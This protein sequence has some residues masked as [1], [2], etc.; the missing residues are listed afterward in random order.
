MPLKN[1][2]AKLFDQMRGLPL[3][4]D[5]A[6]SDYLAMTDKFRAETD[7]QAAVEYCRSMYDVDPRAEGIINEMAQD[8]VKGGFEIRAPENIKAQDIATGLVKRLD[9]QHRLVSWVRET[10]IDGNQ[11]L[12]IAIDPKEL[13]ITDALSLPSL[14]VRRNS[15][16]FD[17]ILDPVK[18]FQWSPLG[19]QLDDAGTWLAEWETIHARW[20]RR[21]NAKYGRPMF[22]SAITAYKR[23]TEG[24]LDMAVRRK[25][26][27][28][29]R[30]LHVLEGLQKDQI[31]EYKKANAEALN[32]PR[33]AVQDF[34]S[35]TKA[36]LTGIQGDAHLA[37]VADVMHHIETWGTSSP[38]PLELLGYGGSFQR[39]VLGAKQEQYAKSLVQLSE[40][41]EAD[42]I[43]PLIEREW[44]FNGILPQDVDYEIEWKTKEPLKAS[45]YRDIADAVLR[46]RSVGL[47][48]EIIFTVLAQFMPNIN[49]DK[50][51]ALSGQFTQ[52]MSP[53]QTMGGNPAASGQQ[54]GQPG[55][56]NSNQLPA[57]KVASTM[58]G[59]G[60][61]LTR[62]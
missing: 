62:N 43:K 25:T 49:L 40:W 41:A 12:L 29:M 52:P 5:I 55:G 10:L 56:A 22:T 30:Y 9:L 54:P 37:E 36:S 32:N 48:D 7:R 2:L 19:L 16:R 60:V 18:A 33:A 34:Y 14:E 47:P 4:P 57:K 38:I 15:D 27:A 59:L 17:R 53:D 24:E 26:R 35:N 58:G 45:D 21:E 23:V 51:I 3:R 1:R 50:L 6:D 42:F 39:D 31:D 20:R 8:I 46:L 11:F 44:L 28:G 13:Q 61:A